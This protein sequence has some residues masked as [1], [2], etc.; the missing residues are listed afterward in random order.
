MSVQKSATTCVA[1]LLAASLASANPMPRQAS[2]ATIENSFGY[3]MT[4]GSFLEWK[5]TGPTLDFSD[6]PA[7]GETGKVQT[8]EGACLVVG[9]SNDFPVLELGACGDAAMITPGSG[10]SKDQM[11]IADD[12][13]AVCNEGG[14]FASY[15]TCTAEEGGQM[16]ISEDEGYI[17]LRPCSEPYKAVFSA[18][19]TAEGG[20]SEGCESGGSE[21]CDGTKEA[22]TLY[23]PLAVEEYFD[24][25]TGRRP[26]F[27]R[28]WCVK[29]CDTWYAVHTVPFGKTYCLSDDARETCLRYDTVEDCRRQNF[30]AEENTSGEPPEVKL[31][32][33]EP[34][35]DQGAMCLLVA[36]EGSQYIGKYV[37]AWYNEEKKVTECFTT[38]GDQD[39]C[40]V[41]DTAA[42][43]EDT[44]VF[45]T[46]DGTSPV[47]ACSANAQA[48]QDNWCNEVEVFL[49][50]YSS[51]NR[52]II[53]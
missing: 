28:L 24:P 7:D 31:T 22:D 10:D 8:K 29:E 35:P 50:Y 6:Y 5:G 44:I 26:G 33:D 45:F 46:P 15:V 43:C 53:I 3:K 2:T 47:K 40:E 52:I 42:E 9:R 1:A 25:S 30:I 21:P 48:A 34:A 49:S 4:G 19:K 27:S 41:Y 12:S 38:S 18:S 20:G 14:E 17:A 23:F 16:C 39:R 36:T 32:Q 13:I 51:E 11:A 37:A